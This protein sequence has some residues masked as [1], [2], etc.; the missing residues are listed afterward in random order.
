[1]SKFQS[2]CWV[3][4]LALASSV[5]A[6][7]RRT[8]RDEVERLKWDLG[9]DVSEDTE[10]VS[11]TLA[12][13]GTA[14]V[15]YL[16]L[17]DEDEEISL[18]VSQEE[19]RFDRAAAQ[20]G[21]SLGE[22]PLNFGTLSMI[23]AYGWMSS[24]P[25][26]RGCSLDGFAAAA[27]GEGLIV[28]SLKV[29]FGRRR[30]NARVGAHSYDLVDGGQSL[31]SG[32]TALAFSLAG[33]IHAWYPD[34]RGWSAIALACSTA[35]SRVHTLAHWPSDVVAGGLIGFATASWV[36]K[37]RLRARLPNLFPVFTRE[38]TGASIQAR[39]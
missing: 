18:R 34:W 17:G 11:P 22:V 16:A 23:G 39:F 31:P 32:H 14:S 30:P 21:R 8:A 24:D 1:M 7:P 37:S 12:L 9:S 36:A 10:A 25:R 19:S 13:A 29:L 3:A 26:A 35:Y 28:P 38:Y 27:L 4:A 5:A 33:T 15:L 20:L 2:I 6:G